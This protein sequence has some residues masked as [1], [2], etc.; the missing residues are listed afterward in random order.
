MIDQQWKERL[1]L[2]YLLRVGRDHDVVVREAQEPHH[3]RL[4][5]YHSS[6]V[7]PGVDHLPPAE[8]VVLST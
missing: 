1:M 8:L 5:P 7:Q 6:M 3:I 4:V 2:S